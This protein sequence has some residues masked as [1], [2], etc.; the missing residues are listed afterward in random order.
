MMLVLLTLAGLVVLLLVVGWV[1]LQVK[2]TSFP[3]Y[4]QESQKLETIPLP[5]GLPAPV[6]RFYRQIYGDTIPV[7]K[8]AVITGRAEVRPAGPAYFPARFRF[9]HVVGQG[10]RHYIEAGLF[11]LPLMKVNER[12]LDGQ[13]YGETPFGVDQGYK[14]DQGANLGMWAESLW[15]PSIYLTD[16]RVH[17]EPV[18]E[19]TALLVVPFNNAQERYVVRFN[20]QTGLI[21]W[22]ESMR[23]HNQSSPEK[24]LWLNQ[25]LE[26]K[27]LNG[28]L[29]NVTGA[30]IWMD[31]GTPW[32]IFHVEDIRF[33]VD[34]QDYIRGRGL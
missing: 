4:S 18:D 5:T 34:V 23:Y 16:S 11:G 8:T 29:T 24:T 6:E 12:Y 14:V 30:A 33:N 25:A 31:N 20:A 3:A 19:N 28:T 7:I 2:P 22:Y 26:W 9:T 27:P 1:G 13:G 21:D 15:M 32:A 10:Y 17:W